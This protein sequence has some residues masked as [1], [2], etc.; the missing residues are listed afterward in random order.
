MNCIGTLDYWR[1][2]EGKPSLEMQEATQ[3]VQP[4]TVFC[5]KTQKRWR[6]EWQWAGAVRDA[7]R[8]FGTCELREEF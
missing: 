5:L 4:G 2:T 8:L 7:G 6:E 1:K 3:E